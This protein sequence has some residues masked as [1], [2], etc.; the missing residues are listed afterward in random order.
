MNLSISQEVRDLCPGAALGVLRYTA[1]VSKS[2]EALL[3]EFEDALNTLSGRYTLEE[4]ARIPHIEATRRAYKALGKDPHQYRCAAEAM[5]RR[6]VKQNGLYHIN[7]VVEVNNLISV[8]SGYS[9]GSYDTECL[10]GDV[11]LKRAEAG[12]HYDGIGKASVN[13]ECLPT[14]YDMNGPFGNP[15]SDS[16]RAMIQP[17]QRQILTVLYAFDGQEDLAPWLV[18]FSECLVRHCGAAGVETALI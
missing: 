6:I 16:R 8:S 9:I 18:R 10:N 5:L 14:L 15:T 4:I 13:I 17:G 12:A 1:Q 11:T 7:N 2:S 3:A